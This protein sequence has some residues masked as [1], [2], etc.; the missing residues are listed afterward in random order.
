M[1][2]N[3]SFFKYSLMY[4]EFDD[5]GGDEHADH[6]EQVGERMH[7]R[8]EHVDAHVVLVL[9]VLFRLAALRFILLL[10]AIG[11]DDR[12]V[13]CAHRSLSPL[14]FAVQLADQV[15]VRVFA[16]IQDQTLP[17]SD[18]KIRYNGL[19]NLKDTDYR[20]FAD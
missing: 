15:R 5:D 6:N 9:R 16:L 17:A 20:A 3:Y 11:V 18:S 8:C 2:T 7:E 4:S 12:L 14:L 10:V 19:F 1:I 13:F